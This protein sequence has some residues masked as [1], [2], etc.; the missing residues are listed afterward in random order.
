MNIKWIK[1]NPKTK[2]YVWTA[3]VLAVGHE[4]FC[5]EHM[6][7]ACVQ[8]KN[9][10]GNTSCQPQ[11]NV[12]VDPDLTVHEDIDQILISQNVWP[13]GSRRKLELAQKSGNENVAPHGEE[14]NDAEQSPHAQ[15]FV[16]LDPQDVS[17]TLSEIQEN[18]EPD[19]CV[20]AKTQV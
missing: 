8:I 20:I 11:I 17:K 18:E 16:L 14:V 10:E 1:K 3:L 9:A 7:D 12:P 15:L 5:Y 19:C 13:Q 4:R 2:S 6:R